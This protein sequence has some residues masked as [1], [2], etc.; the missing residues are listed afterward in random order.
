MHWRHASGVLELDRPRILAIINVTPDSFSDGGRLR[1]VDDARRL[2]DAM[3]ADGADVIDIGGE[4]TRPQGAV[5]V[6]ADEEL[7]RVIPVVAA[8]AQDHRGVPI[9]VD[10]VKSRVA[11]EALCAGASI[12]NDV[13][14]FR[15]DREMPTVC[16]DGGAGVVL[17]HSRGDVADMATFA[18]AVYGSDVV[19]EVIAELSLCV[20]GAQGAGVDDDRIVIDPGIGFSK[21]AEHSLA[22]LG[23]L[24]RFASLNHPVLVG[25]SRKRF[26][27]E[28]SGEPTPAHRVAGTLGAH[29]AAL[30]RGARLFRVHDVK[31]AR[32]SLDVAWAVAKHEVAS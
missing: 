13:S 6:D 30:D 1:S 9:S 31:A 22:I 4:S 25:A 12:I 3:V 21:R 23:Q 15:L 14:G 27:G 19:G 32:Q 17:M 26:V 2:A 29:V 24:R 5:A 20:A 7:R 18:H 11:R 16:A 28:I 10:T 8:V